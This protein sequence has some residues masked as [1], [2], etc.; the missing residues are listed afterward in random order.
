MIKGRKDYVAQKACP[1]GFLFISNSIIT[2]IASNNNFNSCK[3]EPAVYLKKVNWMITFWSRQAPDSYQQILYTDSNKEIQRILNDKWN[4]NPL[5]D[6]IHEKRKHEHLVLVLHCQHWDWDISLSRWT[7]LY[8]LNSQNICVSV[9][10]LI[11]GQGREE[12]CLVGLS[13]LRGDGLKNHEINNWQ[14][15]TCS[16]H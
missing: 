12:I 6:S 8:V 2:T 11:E 15:Q 3:F 13:G 16:P 7:E 9:T 10:A 14:H 5:A 1:A 4:S